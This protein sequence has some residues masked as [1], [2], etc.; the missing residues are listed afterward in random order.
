MAG[1]DAMSEPATARS[2]SRLEAAATGVWRTI[3]TGIGDRLTRAWE[4]LPTS[5]PW[6]A[7]I[8]RDP[9]TISSTPSSVATWTMRSAT[10]AGTMP[11]AVDP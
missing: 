10:V 11:S 3:I 7:P 6:M 1:D 8:P 5:A 4:T 9:T 2:G